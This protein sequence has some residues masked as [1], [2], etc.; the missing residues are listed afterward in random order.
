MM[1]HFIA[2]SIENDKVSKCCCSQAT[3]RL[4]AL[5]YRLMYSSHI[6]FW[7]GGTLA[8]KYVLFLDFVLTDALPKAF[9]LYYFMS[10]TRYCFCLAQGA[11]MFVAA[12][13]YEWFL[14]PIWTFVISTTLI[15]RFI[16][17]GSLV[18]SHTVRVLVATSRDFQQ[19]SCVYS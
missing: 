5:P 9:N 1:W 19:L 4:Y 7:G 18:I 8:A 16:L 14:W 12:M 11:V 3:I 2:S 10:S 17:W 6:D 15:C 13:C